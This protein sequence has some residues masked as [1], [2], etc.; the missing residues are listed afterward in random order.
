MK[1]RILIET[2]LNNPT[3]ATGAAIPPVDLNAFVIVMN[4]LGYDADMDEVECLLA[5]LIYKNYLK[6]YISHKQ[7]K[8]VLKPANPFPIESI[9]VKK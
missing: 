5:N 7:K 9:I 4:A 8:L 2:R 3:I 6:G 1:I